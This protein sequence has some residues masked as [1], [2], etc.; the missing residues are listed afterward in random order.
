MLDSGTRHPNLA[1]MK[2]SGYNKSIGNHVDLLFDYNSLNE[3]DEVYLS[4][5]FDFTKI[6]ININDYPNLITGGTGLY[7][8]KSPQLHCEVEHHMP[9]Y[10]LYDEF[11]DKAI[12]RGIKPI[13]F[14]DYK[15]YSIGFTTRFCVRGCSFCIN[16]NK[17]KVERHSSVSEF[18]D[19][20]R[21]YIYLWD[22]NFLAYP[23]W[24]DVLD[25]IENT[26]RRFQFRQGLDIRFMTDQ[27]A[28]RLS[29][30]KYHG[31]YIFAFDDINDKS[32]VEDK[33]RLWKKYVHKTT[34]LY[35]F[36][37]FDRNNTWDDSFWKQDIIET[38]ERVKILMQFGCLSYIMRY[39]DYELSPYRGT[40]INLARWCNQPNFFKK[41]SYR[42]F[43]LTNGKNSS[44]V[45]YMLEFE[46][47]H[48]EV[49][50]K[51]YDLKFEELNRYKKQ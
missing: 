39:K 2:I 10:S 37:G 16:S 24:E 1:L 32:I 15:D 4:C 6:P 31:D 49:A 45:R 50:Q 11:I 8:D 47:D 9:D 13:T 43:C 25:E 22:D 44:T 48:P 14:K 34:K 17:T 23:K 19:P 27:K 41:K 3:Y 36:C 26:G 18:F 33:L 40:Y 28:V 46:N 21:R 35:V 7:W 20:S 12:K 42:E 29:N 51:Y 5:V 38:F 30:A